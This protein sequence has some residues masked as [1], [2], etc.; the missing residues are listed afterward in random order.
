MCRGLAAPSKLLLVA[1]LILPSANAWDQLHGG[2]DRGAAAIIPER[3]LDVVRYRDLLPPNEDISTVIGPNLLA[4]PRGLAGVARDNVTGDCTLFTVAQDGLGEVAR[5]PLQDCH[6]AWLQGYDAATDAILLCSIESATGPVFQARDAR[7]GSLRWSVQPQ[8]DL[9]VVD[10]SAVAFWGC[11]GVAFD[12]P[13]RLAVAPFLNARTGLDA[14]RHRVA[15]VDLDTG[16]VAWVTEVPMTSP[17]SGGLLLPTAP[18]DGASPYFIPLSATLTTNGVLVTAI[19]ICPEVVTCDVPPVDGSRQ[20]APFQ[21]GV[22]WLN[23]TGAVQGMAFSRE[24]PRGRDADAMA[25]G[26]TAGGAFWATTFGPLG[27]ASLGGYITLINPE[28]K[29]WLSSVPL[30][31]IERSAWGVDS[32]AAPVWTPDTLL[33]PFYRT[34]T[35]FDPIDLSKRWAWA[36]RESG[37]LVLDIATTPSGSVYVLVGESRRSSQAGYGMQSNQTM[38]VKLDGATGSEIQRVPVTSELWMTTERELAIPGIGIGFAWPR[39]PVL[40]P[41]DDGFAVVDLKGHMAV[42]GDGDSGRRPILHVDGAYPAAGIPVTLQVETPAGRAATR[43]LIRW[44]DGAQGETTGGNATAPAT[45]GFTFRHAFGAPNRHEVLVTAVYGDGLTGTASAI[46]D[47]GGTPP[48]DLNLVQQA[49]APDNQNLTFGLLGVVIALLG[50][51]Y[52]IWGRRRRRSSLRRHMAEL[53]A[54]Y[55]AHRHEPRECEARLQGERERLRERLLG[56]RIEE[57]QFA[58]LERRIDELTGRVRLANVDEELAFLP[59]GMVLTLHDMLADGRV[60]PYER[61]RFLRA[62]KDAPGL[63]TDQRRKALA[64]LE[65]LETHGLA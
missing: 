33:V 47:V 55:E 42:L 14:W 61:A 46:V 20:P 56:G 39:P 11:S 19:I 50:G 8:R 6:A 63:T 3:P 49:F 7:D 28:D 1:L 43:I 31:T 41:L 53:A 32:L 30:S 15:A 24:D 51:L 60:T 58:V 57:G 4:T 27:A 40:V 62:L 2:A 54:L 5:V 65:G 16:A 52:A 38:V 45:A 36:T 26:R 21:T 10:S 12:F 17:V 37:W 48:P 25:T 18:V 64:V 34:L 23:R 9:G 44:G 22:A 35:A 59:H 29:D 13:A